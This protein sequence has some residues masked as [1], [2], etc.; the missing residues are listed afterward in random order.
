MD[1]RA[2]LGVHRATF[3]NWI[4]RYVEHTTQCFRAN[5]HRDGTACVSDLLSPDHAFRCI[6][7]EGANSFLTEVLRKRWKRPD[8]VV[9]AGAA[10]DAH[11]ALVHGL[12]GVHGNEVHAD[13][14]VLLLQRCCQ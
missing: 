7:C 5:R 14:D 13:R 12:S 9:V 10:A 1:R 11:R 3:V 6:H 2:L 8:A 4:A